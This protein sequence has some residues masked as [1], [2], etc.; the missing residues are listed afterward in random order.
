M[1]TQGTLQR[2]ADK[3][4]IF[5]KCISRFPPDFFIGVSQH[6]L[7][8][9]FTP[10]V[11]NGYSVWIQSGPGKKYF[12]TG[13]Y[14]LHKSPTTQYNGVKDTYICFSGPGQTV[15]PDQRS[16]PFKLITAEQ[17]PML[18]ADDEPSGARIIRLMLK[19]VSSK[20]PNN[21]PSPAKAKGNPNWR[22]NDDDD[23][24]DDSESDASDDAAEEVKSDESGGMSDD[25]AAGSATKPWTKFTKKRLWA[26]RTDRDETMKSAAGLKTKL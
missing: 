2:E 13:A 15:P 3:D 5:A 20:K 25:G 4:A 12:A 26:F 17:L 7:N 9:L 16:I 14:S 22:R 11:E 18:V 8:E 24:D 21:R 10:G 23:S 6:R 1:D 19:N